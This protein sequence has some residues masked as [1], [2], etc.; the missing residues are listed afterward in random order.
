M[1]SAGSRAK[2]NPIRFV[3][4]SNVDLVFHPFHEL[5]LRTLIR[6][7]MDS[8]RFSNFSRSYKL[9][10]ATSALPFG[11]SRVFSVLTTLFGRMSSAG[12]S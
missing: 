8:L 3:E 5:V 11:I 1:S 10:I 12:A 9:L 4:V 7:G 6:R 2:N